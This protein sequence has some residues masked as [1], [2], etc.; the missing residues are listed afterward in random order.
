MSKLRIFKITLTTK[1]PLQIGKIIQGPNRYY[2]NDYIPASTFRGALI[3]ELASDLCQNSIIMDCSKCNSID[4]CDFYNNFINN[5]YAI[6]NAYPACPNNDCNDFTVPYHFLHLYCKKCKT[7]NID[8]LKN[9]IDK[10]LI[11]FNCPSENCKA[12]TTLIKKYGYFCRDCNSEAPN[13]NIIVSTNTG[14]N[15]KTR[16][17]QKEMLFN[18]DLK[19]CI[20]GGK[21]RFYVEKN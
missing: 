20:N 3:T 10:P 21:Y 11:S 1:A 16:S 8:Y 13:V 19:I 17:S 7:D 14:I 5:F 12:K 15:R 4:N 6:S 9:W 2:S 18:Y